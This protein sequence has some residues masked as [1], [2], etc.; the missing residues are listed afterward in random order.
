M[1]QLG[2][3]MD[4]GQIIQWL[5]KDGEAIRPGDLLLE[6]E[7][8]KSV[9]EVEAVEHGSLRIVK[10]PQDGPVAVG[11]VIA[12]LLAE[13][14]AAPAAVPT[15]KPPEPE[16]KPAAA[17]PAVSAPHAAA[18]VTPGGARTTARS[19][20]AARRR[21]QELGVDWRLATPSGGRGQVKE[22]DVIAL[23]AS[24]S[25]GSGP[26]RISPVARR[27]AQD[28]GIE[29]SALAAQHP[30]KRLQRSDVEG[31]LRGP[32]VGTAAVAGPTRQRIGA[33]RKLIAERMAASSATTAPVTLVTEADASD[34][35]KMR[36]GWKADRHMEFAPSYTVLFAALTARALVEYPY[37]NASFDG[38]EIVTWGTVNLGIAVD[39][40]RGL[41][42]PVVRDVQAKPLR[43][44]AGEMTEVFARASQGKALPDDL[45]G[46]TFTITNLGVYEIDAFTPIIN[47]PE[48][49]VLGIGRLAERIVP[50]AGQPAVRTMVALSLTFDHRLVDGAPAARFLQRVKQF[51]EQP[52]LWMV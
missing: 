22:R 39:T 29:V 38:D 40:D 12:Y 35:V 37:M 41:I 34:L 28:A 20:P 45:T 4:S 18:A 24:T 23:V 31:A 1:P 27:M 7:S 17:A 50:V 47:Y 6:V 5:K 16:A 10:G 51:V 3:S 21:A 15:A 42:V 52:Y 30:G 36:E 25:A 2:L 14:E 8:D 11:S 49:A 13:G 32:A 33:M 26:V 19:S 43:T 46:G 44:L 9:V 48:C